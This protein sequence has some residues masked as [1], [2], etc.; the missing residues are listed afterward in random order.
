MEEFGK[1]VDLHAIEFAYN[2][3]LANHNYFDH[4]KIERRGRREKMVRWKNAF[5]ATYNGHERMIIPF[6]LKRRIFLSYQVGGGDSF[7]STSFFI[8][9]KNE[10]KYEF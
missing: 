3:L 4:S 2:Q 5:I 10:G 9:S 1:N 6:S 7:E 8:V